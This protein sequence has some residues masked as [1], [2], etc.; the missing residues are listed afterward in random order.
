MIPEGMKE[1]ILIAYHNNVMTGHLG[2]K[3]TIKR[4]SQ[5]YFWLGMRKD[6]HEWI[7]TCM[8]CQMRKDE[9][10]TKAGSANNLLANEP[11]ELI[12]M[13]FI[14]PLPTTNQ[15]NKYIIVATDAKTKWVE[16]KTIKKNDAET[17][18]KFFLEEIIGRHGVPKKLIT[19]QRKQ[20]ANEL[21]TE[22]TRLMDVRQNTTTAYRPQANGITERCNKT[23]V[24]IMTMYVN[25][26][27][28]IGMKYYHVHYLP[29]EQQSTV[30][31]MKAHSK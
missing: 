17:T 2:R 23:L 18:A 3:K 13:D 12:G 27:Q 20:F 22:I 8:E 28:R 10:N 19:D 30:A 1:E 11:F 24:G 7:N 9:A 4:I 14:G 29:I 5:R 6:I 21:I 26:H 31:Q 25:K 15:G 16:A